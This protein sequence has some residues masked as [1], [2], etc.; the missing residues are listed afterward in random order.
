LSWI[1]ITV[2][3]A[4]VIALV[5]ISDKTVIYRYARSPLTLPLLIGMAQTTVGIVVL[6]AVQFPP[7]ATVMA[8]GSAL[9]SGALFGFSAVL[10]QRVLFTQEVSRTIPVVQS[11]P[12]F[13]ALLALVVLDESISALQ[14]LGIV[15]TVLGSALLSLRI[16]AGI[17]SVFLHRSFYLLM[18]SAFLFGAANVVGKVAL[19]ELPVLYTH[20][21][22]MLALGSVLLLFSFRS[23]PWADVRSYFSQRSPALLFVG[24]N[25]FITA[26]VGLLLLLWAL[27]VGPASLVTALF[28]TRAFFVVLYSTGLAMIWHGALGEQTSTGIVA[29]KILST[30]LIVV[31][32]VAIAL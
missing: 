31:G 16:T 26:N 11:A 24:T 27:S 13:A 15:A 17:G 19:D 2:I 5:S 23:A 18:F 14:W 8:S 4:A 32:V 20:G 9:L 29:T 25:E 3:S 10:G 22:R 30:I 6:T 21:L 28:G 7:E 12:I 1:V